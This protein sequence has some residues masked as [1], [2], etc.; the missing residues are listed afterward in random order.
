MRRPAPIPNGHSRVIGAEVSSSGVPG[1]GPNDVTGVPA[2]KPALPV[3][4]VSGAVL[5]SD[6]RSA[7]CATTSID[8]FV[9]EPTA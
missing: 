4:M 2:A 3:S 8:W 7:V 1:V 9:G 6:R 5:P